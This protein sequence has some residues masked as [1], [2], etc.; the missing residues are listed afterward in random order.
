MRRARLGQPRSHSRT[1][2]DLPLNIREY[3]Y[4][5]AGVSNNTVLVSSH[6]S[7][8]AIADADGNQETADASFAPTLNLLQTCK[9][10]FHDIMNLL[11]Q[12][13]LVIPPAGLDHGLL[14]LSRLGPEHCRNLDTLHVHLR[15]DSVDGEIPTERPTLTSRQVAAWQDAIRHVLPNASPKTLNLHLIYHA[16]S[17]N[18]ADDYTSAIIQPLLESPGALAK[19]EIRLNAGKIDFRCALAKDTSCRA[20]G[21]FVDPAPRNGGF[22]FF[23]LPKELRRHILEYTDLVTPYRQVVWDQEDGFRCTVLP[24]HRNS[25]DYFRKESHHGCEFHFCGGCGEEYPES[26]CCS[27]RRSAYSASCRCWMAPVYLMVVSRA[28]YIE[29]RDVFYSQN[30]ITVNPKQS[31]ELSANDRFDASMFIMKHIRPDV[32]CHITTLGFV[33]AAVH[34]NH[35]YDPYDPAYSEWLCAV[36]H[37]RS[38]ANVGNLTLSVHM[39]TADMS[40]HS[41]LH[42][43]SKWWNTLT[44]NPETW[45][46]QGCKQL[47]AP[48]QALSCMKRFFVHL[49]PHLHFTPKMLDNEHAFSPIEN[50]IIVRRHISQVEMQLERFVMG[51]AYNS[52]DVG[53]KSQELPHW[54]EKDW[55][56]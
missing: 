51:E 27:G 13:S 41:T 15:L 36:G 11:V 35:R 22:R 25:K 26:R 54:Q 1:L 56:F 14:F 28:L 52:L 47:L 18:N 33:F 37:L 16:P 9:A 24:R 30:L 44:D 8:N 32:T 20:T 50:D 12:N 49:E 5:L 43:F 3:I 40:T 4:V 45:P 7:H 2:L 53:K 55:Y 19:C 34:A 42:T 23:D 46:P 21:R 17:D 31:N 10:V 29:A 38:H 39:F 6:K 48:L